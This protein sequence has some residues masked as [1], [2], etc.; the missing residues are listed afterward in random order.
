MKKLVS[1]L[2]AL[3]ML[4]SIAAVASAEGELK[5]VTISILG[6]YDER[7][8]AEDRS[9][10]PQ[11]LLDDYEYIRHELLPGYEIEI[12]WRLYDDRQ[13]QLPLLMA[14]NDV[15]DI[16]IADGTTYMEYMDTG[17]FLEDLMPM[18]EEYGK[19]ILAGVEQRSLDLCTLK[20]RGLV[21]IPSENFYYKF[22]TIIRTDWVEKLGF[23]V[24]KVYRCV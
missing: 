18:L 13:Q 8:H 7:N 10:C 11:Y 15:P 5:K 1:L 21:A 19:N 6:N 23:E 14:A 4:C 12:Q 3:C 2:L 16:V 17:Y 20:G 9:D 22:R 24:K